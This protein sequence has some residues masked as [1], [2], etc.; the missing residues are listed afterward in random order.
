MRLFFSIFDGIR[1][2]GEGRAYF[3]KWRVFRERKCNFSLDFPAFGLSIRIGPR[4][5]VVLRG[6]GYACAP[7]LWGFDN[8][9]KQSPT[10]L[11]SIFKSFVNGLECLTP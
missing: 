3:K 6:K 8:S 10:R 9:K 2:R 7:V 11:F 1:Q 5:K 4:S